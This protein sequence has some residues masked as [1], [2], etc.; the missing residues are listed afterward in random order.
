MQPDR[1]RRAPLH[2]RR[3]WSEDSPNRFGVIL[4]RGA[5]PILESIDIFDVDQEGVM[6]TVSLFCLVV[7]GLSFQDHVALVHQVLQPFVQNDIAAPAD[8]E[9]TAVQARQ[10][11]DLGVTMCAA[12]RH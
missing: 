11:P 12:Q 7:C 3:S 4:T 5:A 1:P 10:A 9:F 2:N 6:E 8:L